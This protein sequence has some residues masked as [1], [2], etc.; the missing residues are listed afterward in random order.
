[1][2][3]DT[4]DS[5]K[6]RS[7]KLIREYLSHRKRGEEVSPEEYLTK[8]PELEK[9]LKELFNRLKAEGAEEMDIEEGPG[10]EAATPPDTIGD[11]KIIR[12]L[13]SGGMGT[14]YEAEQISLKRKVALKVLPSHL[15]FSDEAVRKFHREAEAG[16]R[17]S[18]PGI[19]AIYA[20]GEEKGVHYIAQELVEEGRTLVLWFINSVTYFSKPKL[21]GVSLTPV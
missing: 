12:E 4:D 20:V 19:V 21:N 17:Q 8:Y 18:H 6:S 2:P 3:A 16:G 1:M 7:E 15:S 10:A 13:G 9:D 11:F 5:R 14:V